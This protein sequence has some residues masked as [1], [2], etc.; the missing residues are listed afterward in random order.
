MLVIPD[1][2]TRHPKAVALRSTDAEHIAEKLVTVFLRVGVPHSSLNCTVCYT[3]MQFALPPTI[4]K[5]TA[6]SSGLTKPSKQC[7]R[8]P[9]RP[10]TRTET[11][12]FYSYYLYIGRYP[13]PPRGSPHLNSFMGG[14]SKELWTSYTSLGKLQRRMMT[15]L[16]RTYCLCGRSCR[17][18]LSWIVATCR[19]DRAPRRSGMIGWPERDPSS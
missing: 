15:V 7:Y 19:Q 16:Y 4:R 1:Y 6:L 8:T 14:L 9:H 18:C 2:A 13:R 5:W 10:K 12:S 3:C 17:R 11:K